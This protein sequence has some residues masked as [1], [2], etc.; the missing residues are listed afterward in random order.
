MSDSELNGHVMRTIR[1]LQRNRGSGV[2][3]NADQDKNEQFVLGKCGEY[4][5]K[6]INRYPVFDR[7][8]LAMI[9]WTL[10]HEKEAIAECLLNQLDDTEEKSNFEDELSECGQDCDDYARVLFSM[11]EKSKRRNGRQL[12]K[13]IRHLLQHQIK[14]TKSNGRS[15]IDINISTIKAMFNLTD[16]EADF[17]I[18]LFVLSTYQPSEDYFVN[19]LGCNKFL[20]RK[21]LVNI[22]GMSQQQLNTILVGVLRNIEMFEMD[23]FDLKLTDDFLKLFEEPSVND[24][25]KDFFC[26]IRESAVPLG[27]H[28]LSEEQTEFILKLLK[29]KPKRG[30]HILLYGPP[31]TGKTTFAY[32][33]A[34]AVRVP[35]Y[36]VV[37]GDENTTRKRRAAILACL[38]MTNTG[39]GSIAVVDE[40]DNLLN[41]RTSWFMR[42]ETQDK[43]WL[44]RLLEEP[45]VRMIWITNR[46]E[47]IDES[48]LR[49]FAFSLHFKPFNKRQR[50]QLW[51]NIIRKNRTKRFVDKSDIKALA[52]K[53]EV[54]AGAI[55]LAVN[56]AI[57]TNPNS[58]PEFRQALELALDA[59]QT[60]LNSG[61]KPMVTQRVE[62]NYTLE[63]LNIECELNLVIKQLE[64]FDHYVCNRRDS[65][66]IKMNLLFYGPPGTGK[67]EF[68]RYIAEHLDREIVCKKASDLMSKWVGGSEKNL[69]NAFQEAQDNEAIFI[70]DEVDSMLFSR[71]RA[72]HSWEISFTNEFLTQM[73]GFSGILICTTN[74]MMDLDAA[75]IRRFNHKIGFNYLTAQ[76]NLIF[77]KKLLA[78]LV[79]TSLSEKIKLE[80]KGIEGLAPGDFKIVRDRYSFFSR[81]ELKH[82]I[83]VDALRDE[84]RLKSIHQGSKAIG[85]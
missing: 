42:G 46:I 17:C 54:S 18:L 57:E 1:Q 32:G 3:P 26:R 24:F 74:R 82:E 85:F 62:N 12:R 41:T 59:H 73:E 5:L 38:N 43:G 13:I 9:C 4:L 70:I 61:N 36:S 78:P 79:S 20:G 15:E 75:S 58:K 55:D 6:H 2:P 67:S 60:L 64:D 27:H 28:F 23:K 22:L 39:E 45:E 30:T 83:L 48:V 16:Q 63:G 50:I 71:D 51:E 77:Y 81:A 44:N 19:H 53:F 8:S 56:K 40:A 80:L 65:N 49:R 34:E 72:Q 47:D 21:Y 37:Q 69:K 68:A 31:G 11:L 25:S 66:T 76:G 14:R 7:E 33:L 52:S 10:G 84:S 35:S 29:N